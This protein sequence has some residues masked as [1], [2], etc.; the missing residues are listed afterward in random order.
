MLCKHEVVGSIPSGS[1]NG[2]DE[3]GG[4]GLGRGS[5]VPVQ[6]ISFALKALL[7]RAPAGGEG[8][9]VDCGLSALVSRDLV[10][11]YLTS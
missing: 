11:W 4:R 10:F 5:K 6:F 8:R 7:L 1:T 3:E 9:A 2:R